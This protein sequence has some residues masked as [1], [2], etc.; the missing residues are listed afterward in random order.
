[1]SNSIFDYNLKQTYTIT[2]N[3]EAADFL[4]A[5]VQNFFGYTPKSKRE[6]F[7]DVWITSKHGINVKTDNLCSAQNQGRL[8]TAAVNQWLQDENN[9]LQFIFI[10]YTNI[11]GNIEIKE[12]IT[13]YIEEVEYRISNQGK[14]LLQ[15]VRDKNYKVVFRNKITR[16]EWLE[17]F[18]E[19]YVDFI[20]KQ[21][22]KFNKLKAKWCK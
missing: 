10:A 4:Q 11:E 3:T 17:E 14:G 19:K 20:N 8:C 21:Q 1:M 16:Q 13:K 9:I 15:P 18:Q 12:V 5:E 6:K 7:A 2:K 22:D